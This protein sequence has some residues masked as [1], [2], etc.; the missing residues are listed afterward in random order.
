[1]KD[2]DGAAVLTGFE[3]PSSKQR[4]IGPLRATVANAAVRHRQSKA[5]SRCT[6]LGF[7]I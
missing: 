3:K 1:L 5:S 7:E 4:A 2:D 6:A